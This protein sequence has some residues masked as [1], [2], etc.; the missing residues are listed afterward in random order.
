MIG[1]FASFCAAA[2]LFAAHEEKAF[3]QWMRSNNNIYTGSE[4]QLR[5]GI[6]LTNKRLIDEHNRGNYTFKAGLNKFAAMTPAEYRSLLGHRSNN[7]VYHAAQRFN[8]PFAAPDSKD[9]REAG[10]VNEIKDQGN[11]GSCWA[12]ATVQ[13]CESAYALANGKLNRCSEQNLVDC[14]H[15]GMCTG[16]DGGMEVDALEYIERYQSYKLMS[17]EDYPY[18]AVTGTK[19]LF[20]ASKAINSIAGYEHT[21]WGKEDEVKAVVGNRGVCTAAMDASRWSFQVYASGVYYEKACSAYSLDHA[22]GLIGYGTDNGTDYWLCRNS[23][24]QGWGEAGYFR[25][26]RNKNNHCGICSNAMLVY[27]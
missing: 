4:Y 17:E 24:G 23:W 21:T 26:A 8:G 14:A 5:L 19:C 20:D 15:F 9:W 25:I 12:F 1:L 22:I 13:A 7:K 2:P 27:S 11:C 3:V 10:I 18:T 16:C 6:F